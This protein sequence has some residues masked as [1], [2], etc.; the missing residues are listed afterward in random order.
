MRN[1]GR[2]E[3]TRLS[4]AFFVLTLALI[5]AGAFG[6]QTKYAP[7]SEYMLLRDAETSLAKSAAPAS[8]SDHATIKTL[9]EHGYEVAQQGDNGWVCFV[10]RGFTGAPTFTPAEFRAIAAYDP[11]FLAPICL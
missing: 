2:Y 3:M 4:I 11:K 6:Q 7:L 1:E 10:M 9:T 5:P 8:I